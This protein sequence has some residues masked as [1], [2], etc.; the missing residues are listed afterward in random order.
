M[1]T[2]YYKI[3]KVEEE[4]PTICSSRDYHF[5]DELVEWEKEIKFVNAETSIKTIKNQCPKHF[6]D[7]YGLLHD[8]VEKEDKNE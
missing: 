4:H 2:I 5:T 8:L 6:K 3:I 1:K 7:T